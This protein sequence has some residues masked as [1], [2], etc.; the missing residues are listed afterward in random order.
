VVALAQQEHDVEVFEATNR[1]GGRILTIPLIESALTILADGVT[2]TDDEAAGSDEVAT[3]MRDPSGD[4]GT[5]TADPSASGNANDASSDQTDEQKKN[6]GD[7]AFWVK[8][9][10][11]RVEL[12]KQVLPKSL[13]S[14]LGIVRGPDNDKDRREPCLI[15]FPS[16]GPPGDSHDP[17]YDLRPDEVGKTP[18]Q[19]LS[20]ALLRIMLRL[21]IDPDDEKIITVNVAEVDEGQNIFNRP[22]EAHSRSLNRPGFCGGSNS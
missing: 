19:L 20:L 12:D 1:W 11:M 10:P 18:M 22:A 13:L 7:L 2:P 4:R 9:G 6:F 5:T 3:A 8:F 14:H 21:E 16:Y 15:P 17:A